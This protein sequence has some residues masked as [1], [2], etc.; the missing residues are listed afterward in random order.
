MHVKCMSNYV[1]SRPR[2]LRAPCQ[3]VNA[4]KARPPPGPPCQIFRSCSAGCTAC[5][6][7]RR[8]RR[9][10]RSSQRRGAASD[11]S[12]W[13]VGMGVCVAEG[14]CISP[15]SRFDRGRRR[16]PPV[17]SVKSRPAAG[18]PV[19]LCQIMSNLRR[20]ELRPPVKAARMMTSKIAPICGTLAPR[21]A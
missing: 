3:I 12:S 21:S 19:K 11:D 15:D 16:P 4:V 6:W 9:G 1:N 13:R 2:D 8:S 7:K 20:D 10:A 5:W 18:P 17:K 14:G